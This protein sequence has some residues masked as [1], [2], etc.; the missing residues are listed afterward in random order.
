[1]AFC[2]KYSFSFA[3]YFIGLFLGRKYISFLSIAKF[4]LPPTEMDFVVKHAKL[5][6]KLA[7]IFSKVR[8]Y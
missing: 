4:C 3:F 2:Q 8:I 7:N 5:F 1:M 6:P